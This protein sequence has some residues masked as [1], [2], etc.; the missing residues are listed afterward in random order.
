MTYNQ[1]LNYV[2]EQSVYELEHPENY[3]ASINHIIKNNAVEYDGIS[4]RKHGDELAPTVYLNPF[5][6][7]YLDGRPL[8]SILGE[9]VSILQDDVP[10][11]E[12]PASLYDNYD[13]VRSQIIF[14]LVNYKRNQE[15]LSDCPYLPFCDLAITFRWLV[16]IDSQSIASS[17]ITNREVELWNVSI[18]E[19][20]QAAKQNTK[21]LF[22]CLIQP[23]DVLLQEYLPDDEE[24]QGL[25]NSSG[26]EFQ[27]HIL[28][29]RSKINGSTCLIYDNILAEFSSQHHSDIYI[30]P[31]SIHE[32]LLLPANPHI[33][34]PALLSLVHDANRT[35]VADTDFLSDSIYRYDAKRNRIIMIQNDLGET[36]FF[37]SDF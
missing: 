15:Q 9:I 24:L 5:Y 22:P 4:L 21:Q 25:F 18:Q 23:L 32:L 16:H 2:K 3:Q 19:L 12:V 8:K 30:L 6:E 28:T 7:Q 31:S 36:D 34:E 26:S 33:E 27:L 35:V 14:Q 1:F 10:S 20:Y 11:L 29:N 37:S 17:L 13:A